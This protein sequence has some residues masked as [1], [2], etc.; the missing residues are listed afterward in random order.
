MTLNNYSP[1]HEQCIAL[2]ATF[3]AAHLVNQIAH[4][5]W[6]FSASHQVL[7]DSLFKFDVDTAIDI[8]ENVTNLECGLNVLRAQLG[9]TGDARDPMVARYVAQLLALQSKVRKDRNILGSLKD[10][11]ESVDR[12]RSAY[13]LA[14]STILAKLAE[15]YSTHVSSLRPRVLIHGNQLHLEPVENANAVRALLLAGVRAAVLWAQVKGSRWKIL[16]GRGRYLSAANEL[17][18]AAAR[19][20]PDC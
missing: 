17:V 10:K 20:D 4:S 7:I 12:D 19:A 14:E 18:A 11:L 13:E 2:A 1:V 8:Y 15:I 9:G 3:Q 16:A 6:Q 5:G